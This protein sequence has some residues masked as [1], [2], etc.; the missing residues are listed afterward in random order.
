M[1]MRRVLLFVV[2]LV[3]IGA[4]AS[5]TVPR[6]QDAPERQ[7]TP[8]PAPV[9]PAAEVVEAKLPGKS[10]VRARVGDIVQLQ[11]SHDA[12]DEVQIPTLGVSEPVDPGLPAQLVFDADRP[13]RFAVTL[14]DAEKRIG[15]VDV[16]EAG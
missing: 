11:V 6:E 7:T 14:R 13:G 10:D 8:E 1:G 12:Q 2:L 3:V 4:V 9:S 16:Q 15:T 5:A